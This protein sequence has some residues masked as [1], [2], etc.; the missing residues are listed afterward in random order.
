IVRGI[1]AAE[2]MPEDDD[3]DAA[4]DFLFESADNPVVEVLEDAPAGRRRVLVVD[5]RLQA[6]E[7]FHA[8]Q[9]MRER[10]EWVTLC[11]LDG[12]CWQCPHQD[13]CGMRRARTFRELEGALRRGQPAGRPVDVSLLDVRGDHVA[14]RDLLPTP[15]GFEP[16]AA[17]AA[18]A[19]QGP[20]MV[21]ARTSRPDLHE[22]PVVL[23]TGRG[24]LPA[25][26]EK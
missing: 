25:G 22:P 3:E 24:A 7:R 17:E 14:T 13:G 12:P 9:H 6:V 10:F 20:L 23:M 1:E 4:L 8:T 5:D 2:E 26:S 21:P 11:E 18:R 16:D 19:L 15:A